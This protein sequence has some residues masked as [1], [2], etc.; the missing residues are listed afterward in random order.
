MICKAM[1]LKYL[2]KYVLIDAFIDIISYVSDSPKVFPRKSVHSPCRTP[3]CQSRQEPERMKNNIRGQEILELKK[4][5]LNLWVGSS[6]KSPPCSK[7]SREWLYK[8]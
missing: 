7:Y 8:S 6:T 5:N 3:Q 1:I 2:V 4:K